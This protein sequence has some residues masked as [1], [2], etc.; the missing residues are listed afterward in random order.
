[1]TRVTRQS[2]QNCATAGAGLAA[3]NV[4]TALTCAS[5]S[6][7]AHAQHLLNTAGMVL[8]NCSVCAL[9]VSCHLHAT[10]LVPHGADHLDRSTCLPQVSIYLDLF[11]HKLKGGRLSSAEVQAVHAFLGVNLAEFRTL[12]PSEVNAGSLHHQHVLHCSV[13]PKHHLNAYLSWQHVKTLA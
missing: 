8:P 2:W 13:T 3:H 11:Q 7:R 4:L 10:P 1:M 12:A 6:A 5:I 9:V